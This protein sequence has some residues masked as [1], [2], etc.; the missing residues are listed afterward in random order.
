MLFR[1]VVEQ[2]CFNI[3]RNNTEE[4][5]LLS[6]VLKQCCI[7]MLFRLLKSVETMLPT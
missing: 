4:D 2:H 1:I 5:D 6:G 3:Q 7:A